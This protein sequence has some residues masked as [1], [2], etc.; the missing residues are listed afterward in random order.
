MQTGLYLQLTGQPAPDSYP[1]DC[2]DGSSTLI[3]PG[4]V[5]K[6]SF[7]VLTPQFDIDYYKSSGFSDEMQYYSVAS[8][9]Q[10]VMNNT[11]I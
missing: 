11:E 10:G 4:A 8:L 6:S 9:S 1:I 3:P 5:I 2:I 7:T